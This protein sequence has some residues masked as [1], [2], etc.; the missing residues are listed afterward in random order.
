MLTHRLLN[1]DL[2]SRY[3]HFNVTIFDFLSFQRKLS[4]LETYVFKY[5]DSTVHFLIMKA[6]FG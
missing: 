1:F 2:V 6:Y 3:F 5:G 4:Y